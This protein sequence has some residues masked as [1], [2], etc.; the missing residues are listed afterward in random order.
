[1]NELKI[2]ETTSQAITSSNNSYNSYN[3]L[4]QS[5]KLN[6]VD[7]DGYCI[8]YLDYKVIIGKYQNGELIFEPENN[9]DPQYL[10]RLR[11]FNSTKEFHVWRISSREFNSR[12][13]VDGKEGEKIEFIDIEQLVWG[14]KEENL[15]RKNNIDFIKLTNERGMEII[16]PAISSLKIEKSNNNRLFVRSRNYISY[17]DLCQPEYFDHRLVKFSVKSFDDRQTWGDI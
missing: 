4:L 15:E 7:D 5:I 13:R 1:M 17:N 9:F 12:L 16:L 3:D 14:S 11:L 8:A 10:Q 2:E 6:F